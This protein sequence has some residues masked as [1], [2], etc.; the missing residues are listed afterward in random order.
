MDKL[1]FA[2]FCFNFA[3][4]TMYMYYSIHDTFLSIYMYLILRFSFQ[5]PK[6]WKKRV[7][8][9]SCSLTVTHSIVISLELERGHTAVD[10][11]VMQRSHTAVDQGVM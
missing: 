4:L 3:D 7:F 9:N 10:Q 1:I 5:S 2:V 6:N 11:G 8:T